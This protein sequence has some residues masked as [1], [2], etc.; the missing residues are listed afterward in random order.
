MDRYSQEVKE[1]LLLAIELKE[2]VDSSLN[3]SLES[4]ESY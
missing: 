3:L 1:F 2:K 4:V